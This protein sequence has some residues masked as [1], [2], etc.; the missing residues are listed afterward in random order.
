MQAGYW[1]QSATAAI[2]DTDAT[3]GTKRTEL[4]NES[5][6]EISYSFTIE[7][8]TLASLVIAI[9]TSSKDKAVLV[10]DVTLNKAE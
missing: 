4:T 6:Q 8:G 1:P 2:Y 3:G 10:D 9:P 7:E 5:W